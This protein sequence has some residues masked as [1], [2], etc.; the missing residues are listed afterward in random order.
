MTDLVFDPKATFEHGTPGFT[1]TKAFRCFPENGNGLLFRLVNDKNQW[2]FYN[3]TRDM[4][5]RVA[6]KL[7]RGSSVQPLGRAKLSELEEEEEEEEEEGGEE[8]EEEAEGE[9]ERSGEKRIAVWR[10]HVTVVVEPG[11]TERFLVG[12]V[13]GFK[14][15]FTS[16]SMP[17][18]YVE[19]ENGFPA[20]E[21]ERVYKCLQNHGNGLL[22][23]LVSMNEESGERTWSYYNDA[24]DFTME[25][26]VAFAD[27][28]CVR[29][30]GKTRVEEP[31]ENVEG[32]VY[33]ISVAPLRTEAF[34]CGDPHEYRQSILA[35]PIA[36]DTSIDPSEICFENGGP[37]TNVISYPCTK[38]FKGF[39]D[40]GNGLVFLLV[41]EEAE[42]WAFYNDTLDYI[43]TLTVKFG[44]NSVYEVSEKTS[45]SNDPD[46]LGGTVCVITVPPLATE[47]FITR[48]NPEE[49]KLFLLAETASKSKPEEELRYENGGPSTSI[50]PR[51]DKVYKCFK[52]R[53]NG[54][55]FRLVDEERAEWA[56]YNDTKNC[57]FTVRV[58]FEQ[59]AL[60]Q[61][62][63]NT[64]L[65]DD[66]DLGP[67]YVLEV[68]PLSTELFVRGGDL[69]GFNV[70]FSGKKLRQVGDCEATEL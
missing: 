64:Q 61:A 21:Y 48:G 26:E 38:V 20:V 36:N 24:K 51:C 16:E 9:E 17:E 12:D 43:I 15:N 39:K 65:E 66:V 35:N 53:G 40:K 69:S 44:P 46:V 7:G 55:L 6:A 59:D 22:F 58:N 18:D 34:L 30:L 63:G 23:R 25:V 57:V 62:L 27:K 11:R 2:A 31:V 32:A 56:F 70:K 42:K 67:A 33:K 52:D 47:L 10:Y 37:D 5:F 13:K 14:L 60:V 50:M 54:L 19:F 8:E 3:D 4:L 29:P 41:D 1:Y 28:R 45:V 49:Y 68:P